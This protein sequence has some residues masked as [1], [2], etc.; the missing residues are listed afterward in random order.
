MAASRRRMKIATENHGKFRAKHPKEGEHGPSLPLR[1]SGKA[2]LTAR[3]L[4]REAPPT[5]APKTPGSPWRP[6][7]RCFLTRLISRGQM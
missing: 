1:P 7:A 2:H 5:R 6:R 3:G 4:A